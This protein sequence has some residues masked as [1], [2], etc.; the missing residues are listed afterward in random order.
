MVMSP[1]EFGIVDLKKGSFEALLDRSSGFCPAADE[2]IA[3]GGQGRWSDETVDRVQVGI[4]DLADAL[5]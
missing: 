5:E 1:G 3:Q 4:F 2:T